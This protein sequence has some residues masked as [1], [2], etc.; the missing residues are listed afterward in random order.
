MPSRVCGLDSK[1]AKKA[2]SEKDSAGRDY[3]CGDAEDKRV[4]TGLR[5]GNGGRMASVG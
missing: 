5:G 4:R 3:D 1:E 2:L